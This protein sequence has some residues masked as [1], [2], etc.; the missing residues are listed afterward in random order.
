MGGKDASKMIAP[1]ARAIANSLNFRLVKTSICA[2]HW[3]E[4]T[5]CVGH[6]KSFYNISLLLKDEVI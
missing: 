6:V 5:L 2:T 1:A 4:H 3:S